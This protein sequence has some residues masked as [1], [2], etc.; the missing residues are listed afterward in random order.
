MSQNYVWPAVTITPGG[1]GATSANQ[2]LEIA[3]LTAINSNTTGVATESTL[4]AFSNKTA[5]SLV[6]VAYDYQSI[7]YVGVTTNIDTVVYK[8]GGAGGTTVATLTMGYDGSS[9][10]TSVT[11]S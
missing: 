4:A 6:A 5:S 11:R 10:L 3:Q 1:G 7:S 2:V 8:S 9:R